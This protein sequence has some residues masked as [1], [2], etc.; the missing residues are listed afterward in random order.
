MKQRIGVMLLVLLVLALSA[1]GTSQNSVQKQGSVGSSANNEKE[2]I[3]AA[4]TAPKPAPST[5]EKTSTATFTNKYGTATTKCAHT[6]C[7]NYIASSG[8]TNCCTSHSN[9][10][11]ECNKYI[12]E[13]SMYCM[14]CL[15]EASKDAKDDNNSDYDYDSDYDFDSDDDFDFDNDYDYSQGSDN[16]GAGGYEM[17]NE[18]DKSFSDYVQRVDPELYDELFSD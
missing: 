15:T 11:L 13:D 12:D 8:D 2:S 17:P 6:G 3:A 1:C 18:S 16:I 7:N 14:D 4:T 5:E 9:R 10:C